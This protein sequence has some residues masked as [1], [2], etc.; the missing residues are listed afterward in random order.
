[1]P[2]LLEEKNLLRVPL[3][4]N[5]GCHSQSKAIKIALYSKVEACSCLFV[6]TNSQGFLS[7]G[8]PLGQTSESARGAVIALCEAPAG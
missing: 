4:R 3:A 8:P 6:S 1:M 7:N 2:C 5:R